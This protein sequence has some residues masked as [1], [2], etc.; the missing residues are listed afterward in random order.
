VDTYAAPVTTLNPPPPQVSGVQPR[1]IQYP[2]Q[3]QPTVLE[4]AEDSLVADLANSA[5]TSVPFAGIGKTLIKYIA[6]KVAEKS[7]RKKTPIDLARMLDEKTEKQWRDWLP[8]TLKEYCGFKN[9]EVWRLDLIMAT[10]VA[11]TNIDV[12]SDWTLFYAVCIAFNE[13]R[14]NFDWIDKPS[15]MEC[16]LACH[17]LRALRPNVEFGPGVIRFICAVMLEDGLVYFPWTGVD[18]IM[19]DVG[20]GKCVTG[21]CEVA[22]LAKDMKKTWD[23][24]AT[25]Y[26][27]P[28]EHDELDEKDIH[29]VQLAKLMNGEAYI[30]A[31]ESK[32]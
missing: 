27:G 3:T 16:A 4:P 29:E 7:E 9:D 14:V 25:N 13:R 12:F 18:G 31:N 6:N 2:V 28:A 1:P 21:L 30:H 11:V 15:Y 20:E 10:Q 32:T 19:L 17:W 24:M 22:S 5:N 8:E 26:I 23:S